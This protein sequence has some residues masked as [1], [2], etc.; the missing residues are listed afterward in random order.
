MSAESALIR[1]IQS[2]EA[3]AVALVGTWGRGKTYLW[4]NLVATTRNPTR[5]KY[6]YVSLFGVNDLDDLRLAIFQRE[7]DAGPPPPDPSRWERLKKKLHWRTVAETATQLENPWVGNL[8]KLYRTATFSRVRD[9]LICFDDFE[10]KG[11]DLDLQ[12]V[13][14]LITFLCE[15]RNCAVVLILNDSTMSSIGE[16]NKYREKVFHSEVSYRPSTE[17]CLDIIF[18]AGDN[19]PWF[20]GARTVLSKLDVSN[21]RIMTRI[22]D[23]LA[24]LEDRY[25]TASNDIKWQIG[26]TLGLYSY[27]HNASGEGAPSVERALKNP[28]HRI[29]SA[30]S[31]GDARTEEEKRWDGLLSKIDFYPDELDPIVISYVRDG[32]P[33]LVALDAQV[34]RM[35]A[36]LQVNSAD[37]AYSEAWRAYHDSFEDNTQEIVA[38]FRDSFSSA[39]P[40]MNAMNANSTIAL[41]RRLGEDD[42][43][44]NFIRDW[45]DH[46]RGKRRLELSLREA[47]VFGPLTDTKFIQ[48]L[49]QAER[50]ETTAPDFAE[51][52]DVI[53]QGHGA[54]NEALET[55][56]LSDAATIESWFEANA[57]RVS[58]AFTTTS[59]Q[60]R[61][62]DHVSKAQ[63]LIREALT[64]LKGRSPINEIRVGGILGA[65]D[66]P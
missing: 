17:A 24:P 20:S 27:C 11:K 28:Y 39:A 35:E 5:K 34:A 21:M 53:A 14:G 3:R 6:S 2:P 12:Q 64:N 7:I 36:A 9:R 31:G 44:D 56:S 42:L 22:K 52:M 43:A 55:I 15:E 30:S 4:R 41:M 33:D 1:L 16:W 29:V 61:G 63:A 40:T 25:S 50:E 62:D 57:G 66:D 23:A 13:L 8:N 51:A 54:V 46:R 38:K 65:I 48:A 58:R 49:N 60:Y 10:R 59:M 37:Q 45:I 26:G 19:N 32:Y 47:Q 18:G